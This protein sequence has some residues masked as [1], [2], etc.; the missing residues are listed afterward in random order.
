MIEL[1]YSNTRTALIYRHKIAKEEEM[2]EEDLKA[3][4]GVVRQNKDK[5]QVHWVLLWWKGTLS[6]NIYT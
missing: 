1:L 2:E 3:R 6:V 5:G 4:R